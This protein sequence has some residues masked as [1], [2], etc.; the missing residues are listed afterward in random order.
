[1]S[2]GRHI[3]AAFVSLAAVWTLVAPV[4]ADAPALPELPVEG[5]L[6]QAVWSAG[7]A[8]D[9][10]VV[11]GDDTV[12]VLDL[13]DPVH[14]ALVGESGS[15]GGRVR[16][17]VASESFMYVLAAQRVHVLDISDP[18][19]PVS[20]GTVDLDGSSLTLNGSYLYVAGHNGF[21]VVDVADPTQPQVVGQ[22][23]TQPNGFRYASAVAIF[24]DT[25]YVS[26]YYSL[27]GA[28]SGTAVIDISDV[29]RPTQ[30]GTSPQEANAIALNGKYAYLSWQVGM[31]RYAEPWGLT[32]LNLTEARR[33]TT[34]S[35]L[36][37]PAS[38]GTWG[39]FIA[40]QQ[41]LLTDTYGLLAADVSDPAHPR[42]TGYH[43]FDNCFPGPSGSPA[44]WL[45]LAQVGGIR[46]Q[47]AYVALGPGGLW[48][49]G[50]PPPWS[51]AVASQAGRSAAP[52]RSSGGLAVLH[53]AP[54]TSMATV[55]PPL[56]CPV[57]HRRRER[58]AFR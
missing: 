34:V 33:P 27:T 8:G 9:Y 30:V 49:L 45:W 41:A 19:A 42:W 39:V 31:I 58:C 29:S 15:L 1:M 12:Q 10:L 7:F 38:A 28:L 4:A 40:D 46:D 13:T 53:Q 54:T 26:P 6:D 17:L 35:Y 50:L 11:G 22:I 56:R 3:A 23:D 20:V 47:H 18:S 14:P 5:H 51:L 37:T 55:G 52:I 48:V 57:R 43:H 25:A 32:I 44:C 24:G 16:P 21:A 2:H 36:P